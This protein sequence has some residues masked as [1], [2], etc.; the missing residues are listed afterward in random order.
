LFCAPLERTGYLKKILKVSF[1][2]EKFVMK[3]ILIIV[4][5]ATSVCVLFTG[6]SQGFYQW[7][8]ENGVIHY[9][10]APPDSADNAIE[11]AGTGAASE[12]PEP[13]KSLPQAMPE[14]PD[15]LPEA[16]YPVPPKPED[17]K[18]MIDTFSL[19]PHTRKEISFVSFEPVRI[20]F[21]T[22]I[23]EETVGQC[24][25]SGAGIKDMYSNEEAISPYGGS[26]EFKSKN[27]YIK[28]V[29]GNLEDFPI[30]IKVFK[31]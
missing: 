15:R 23:T 18:E 11:N 21:I 29:V 7:E 31:Q 22:D 2:Q 13:E 9:G 10:D 17:I 8:D 12:L 14:E 1:R 5:L 26:C 3:N 28:F 30:K 20:G 6:Q 24:K 19:A 27:G 16:K 25:N 4:L